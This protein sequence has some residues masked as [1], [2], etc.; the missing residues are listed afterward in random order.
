M[1]L[2]QK[3]RIYP[4]KSHKEFFAKQF[5]CCRF[6]WN[7][8]I[9][10]E[11]KIGHYLTYNEMA[12]KLTHELK[13]QYPFLGDVSGQSLQQTLM[14]LSKSIKASKRK[15]DFLGKPKFKKKDKQQ[16]CRFP[17]S[18]LVNR[19][20]RL[21][22]LP[23]LMKNPI[24]I[25]LERDLPDYTMVTI[26]K[27]SDDKWYACFIIEKTS[28]EH[29][30][31][32]NLKHLGIDLGL[33]DLIVTSEGKHIAPPHFF[34][35]VERNIK[36]KNKALS[37][38]IKGSRRW[39]KCC[40]RL[41]VVQNRVRRQRLDFAHK[42]TTELANNNNIQ[43]VAVETLKIKNMIKNHRL[44]KSISDASWYLLITTLKYKLGMRGKVLTF[45]N[46]MYPSTR[47]C[48]TCDNQTGPKNNLK[49]RQW[50]CSVCGQ[51]HDR[52][53]NAAKN[54]AA[55]ADR[56]YHYKPTSARIA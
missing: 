35:K 40:K 51:N 32:H 9:A 20:E 33:K 30:Y 38:K 16:S 46:P 27:E 18:T 53:I 1:H 5:G 29:I 48:S 26:V 19:L 39:L 55:E 43:G 36:R 17:Q 44:A 24:K 6:V 45:V 49:I 2:I 3:H 25:V 31:D 37:K 50:I 41:A 12:K 13:L 11:E 34:R 47:L 21:L 28:V 54:I 14:N 15:T 56:M 52:D 8:F 22:Y 10:L 4:N 7:Y 23:K 42:L